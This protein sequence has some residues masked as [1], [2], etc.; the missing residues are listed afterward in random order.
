VTLHRAEIEKVAERGKD[1]AKSKISKI[2]EPPSLGHNFGR[3]EEC[4][5]WSKHRCSK[6]EDSHGDC[7]EW[8]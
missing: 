4:F 2:I 6:C 7:F 1:F 3:I 8:I 5:Q